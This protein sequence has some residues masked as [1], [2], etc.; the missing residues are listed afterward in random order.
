LLTSIF[1]NSK[2]FGKPNGTNAPP[3]QSKLSFATKST[4]NGTPSSSSAKENENVDMEDENSDVEVKPKVK[5]EEAVDTKENLK[6][7]KGTLSP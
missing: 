5:K 4:N 3:K 2:F 6:A 7:R 1:Y